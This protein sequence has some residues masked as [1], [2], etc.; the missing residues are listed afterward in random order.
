MEIR[1]MNNLRISLYLALAIPPAIFFI[2][3]VFLYKEV[4]SFSLGNIL[5]D[6]SP[7]FIA[8]GSAA[9]IFFIIYNE[10]MLKPL[11]IR[12][13]GGI[14]NY[15]PKYET[16]DSLCRGILLCIVLILIF[17][18]GIYLVY[19]SEVSGLGWRIF[20]EFK[21]AFLT[22][23]I[24]L[25]IIIPIITVFSYLWRTGADHIKKDAFENWLE[26]DFPSI[27]IKSALV[28]F[29]L[30]LAVGFFCN[31]YTHFFINPGILSPTLAI[32]AASIILA[33]LPLYYYL[34]KRIVTRFLERHETA[35]TG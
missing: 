11:F 32:S 19:P 29:F 14:H 21:I 20:S 25:S 6:I 16:I 8:F 17:F 18:G 26:T 4:L 30:S 23:V 9:S 13:R 10:V 24:C 5:R 1:H 15:H 22:V 27:P 2:I 12:C 33:L 3:L 28:A 34:F 7:S 31:A 35:L